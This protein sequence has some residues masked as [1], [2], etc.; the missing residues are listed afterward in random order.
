MTESTWQ[1]IMASAEPVSIPAVNSNGTDVVR[2]LR[3][4]LWMSNQIRLT[5][6]E[7]KALTGKGE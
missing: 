6:S 2:Q 7:V 3:A 1:L 5:L 4:A